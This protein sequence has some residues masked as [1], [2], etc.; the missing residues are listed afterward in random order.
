MLIRIGLVPGTFSPT[1]ERSPGMT[2]PRP[3]SM[4]ALD[5]FLWRWI[6]SRVVAC[7]DSVAASDC[8][9]PWRSTGVCCCFEGLG[10]CV[11]PV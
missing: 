5:V 10:L 2:V 9:V 4:V 8:E 11:G 7:R 6:I 3:R 1:T